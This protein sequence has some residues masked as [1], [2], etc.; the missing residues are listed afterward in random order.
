MTEDIKPDRVYKDHAKKYIESQGI[1]VKYNMQRQTIMCS[2]TI[3]Q[4]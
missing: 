4:R 1:G 2:A 3:P